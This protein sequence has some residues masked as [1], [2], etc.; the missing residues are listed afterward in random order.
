M[1]LLALSPPPGFLK[2]PGEPTIQ[3]NSW[4]H[5]FDKYVTAFL[6]E[7]I[8]EK[9]KLVL[10]IHC[11]S[12]ER[13]SI[14]YTLTMADD[15]HETAKTCFRCG[16]TSHL[17][18]YPNCPAKQSNCRQCGKVGH[19]ARDYHSSTCNVQEVAVPEL[20]VFSVE[21]PLPLKQ[22]QNLTCTVSLHTEGGKSVDTELLVD[23]GSAVYILPEHLYRQH[24]SDMSL[25]VPDVQLVT[26]MKKTIPVLGGLAIAVSYHFH[27][28]QASFHIIP[29]GI[30]LLGMDLFSALHLDIR[31]G[32]VAS[33][34]GNGQVAV[35]F[36]EPLGLA[37][38]F[39]HKVNVH[40]DVP[41][42]QQKLRRLL[43]Q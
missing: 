24:F 8:A 33:S 26:Y 15:R 12:M 5:M 13:Q 23:I 3:F 20:T 11:W 18:N 2:M 10:L 34:A 25:T 37:A 28:A 22:K 17:A 16:P 1:A 6:E 42:V 32:S 29:G 43:S 30:P 31:N 41:P 35:N 40:S 21:M 9:R 19:F 38:G 14:F 39:V 27:H 4:I 36:T 7:D